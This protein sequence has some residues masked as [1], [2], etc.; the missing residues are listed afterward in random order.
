MRL[1]LHDGKG[2]AL[3]GT[4]RRCY[5][6][7]VQLL[8]QSLLATLADLDFAHERERDRVSSSTKDPSLQAQALRK[9]ELEHQDRREPYI[10]DLTLIRPV[11]CALKTAT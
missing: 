6:P 3:E 9:L 2:C 7:D 5:S 11:G 10:R 8:I 1:F 4:E